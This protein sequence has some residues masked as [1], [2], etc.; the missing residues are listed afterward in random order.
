MGGRRSGF[1]TRFGVV[2]A[3]VGVVAGTAWAGL[4]SVGPAAAVSVN[5]PCSGPG[6]GA[7]GLIAA[8]NA[9]NGGGGGNINLAPGCTYLLTQ[10]DNTVLGSNG[11]PVITSPITLNGSSTTIERSSEAPAFRILLVTNIGRLT[12]N[13]VIVTGGRSVNAGGG[14]ITNQ[15]YLTLNNNSRVTGNTDPNGD[16]GGGIANGPGPHNGPGVLVLNNSRVDH[17]NTTP[18]CGDGGGIATSGTTTVNNSEVDSNGASFGGGGIFNF[19]G[20]GGTGNSPGILTLN[21]SRVHDNTARFGGGILNEVFTNS[22]LAI[23]ASQVVQNTAT[24]TGGGI[25][26]EAGTV[27]LGAATVTSNTPN[28]CFPP[29]SV[30]GCTN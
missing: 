30:P 12:L 27:S 29:G 3:V 5:V 10:V 18:C 8:I 24:G 1:R 16:G 4:V 11:L 7:P 28:N 22:K 26:N 6:G 13:N 15:G 17:N 9:A 19:S 14:G 20:G 21:N 2:A 25:F 23:N